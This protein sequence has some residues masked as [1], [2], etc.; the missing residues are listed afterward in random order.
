MLF[1]QQLLTDPI[2]HALTQAFIQN[3]APLA[4][5]LDSFV[6]RL[7]HARAPQWPE[8]QKAIHCCKTKGA[9]LL[10]LELGK[11]ASTPSFAALLLGSGI[12][13][14]CADQPFVTPPILEA[15]SKHAEIQRNLHGKLIREGLKMTSA[16]S[17]NP[18]AT[19]VIERVNKPKID[20]AILF[21]FLLEP[22]IKHY[23][24]KIFAASNGKNT[25]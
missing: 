22:L 6:E 12:P 24:E 17:G 20:T 13:F 16:K 1:H 18:H 25:Q 4:H 2:A 10:I 5:I 21:A 15:L 7:G 14:L 3:Q 11:L 23:Q 9:S 19:E 8:L